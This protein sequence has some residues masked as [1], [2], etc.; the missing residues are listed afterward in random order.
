MMSTT[1][2]SIDEALRLA[3]RHQD[4]GRV[5]EAEK[6]YRAVLAIVPSHPL[7]L[8]LLGVLLN[9]NGRCAEAIAPLER[10]VSLDPAEA[11]PRQH[12]ANALTELGRAEEA[13]PHYRAAIE[14]SPRSADA[15]YNLGVALAELRRFEEAI[16]CYERAIALHPDFAEAHAKLGIALLTT[17]QF[18]RGWSEYEWRLKW[19][20]PDRTDVPSLRDLPPRGEPIVL[21]AEQ[22]FG[23]TIQLLRYA[24][25]AAGRRGRVAVMCPPALERLAKTVRG[26]DDVN[27]F[28]VDV[29]RTTRIPMASLPRLFGTTLDRIPADVPYVH[30]PPDAV[31]AWRARIGAED[32]SVAHV[33]LVWAGSAAQR[34]DRWRSCRLSDLAPLRELRDL[35]FYSLQLGPAAEQLRDQPFEIIDLSSHL[36]DF[37]ET[38]AA[39]ANLDLVITVDTA[40]AH[41][42]GAM[43]RPVWNMLFATSD[44]RWLLHREDSPW[45]PTMRLFRQRERGTWDDVVACVAEELRKQSWRR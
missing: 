16:G 23:D 32:P 19:T 42:A 31:E 41:L 26:V 22:G 13:L 44:W 5:D 1:R 34:E 18:G 24:T 6:L 14:L 29:Q 38:A 43:G 11:E 7:A 36:T 25:L 8:D 3:V 37:A 4:A 17:G 45:Y 27:A 35:R 30:P 2:L 40:V 15:H 33:G 10:A 12:L 39:I 28:R 20:R 9:Q 21:E